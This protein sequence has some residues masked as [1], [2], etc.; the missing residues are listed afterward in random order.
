MSLK[1]CL[2]LLE[3][4]EQMAFTDLLNFEQ[5]YLQI[6]IFVKSN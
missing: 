5:H 3:R 4:N 2:K 1:F 6:L